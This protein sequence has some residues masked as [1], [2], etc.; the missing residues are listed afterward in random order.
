MTTGKTIALTRWT[1]VGKVMSPLLNML[2]RVA[3]TFLPRSKCLLISWLQSPSVVILDNTYL[4]LML[5]LPAFFCITDKPCLDSDDLKALDWTREMAVPSPMR[6][7]PTIY[8]H[9]NECACQSPFRSTGISRTTGIR[10]FWFLLHYSLRKQLGFLFK[11]LL[12]F[13]IYYFIDV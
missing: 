11:F 9:P 1:F 4:Q 3:I 13:C 8:K 6:V 5:S 10:R 7:N 2:S 12:F